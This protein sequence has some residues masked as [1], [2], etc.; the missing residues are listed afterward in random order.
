LEKRVDL[1]LK[2]SEFPLS[3]DDLCQLWLALAH[4]FWRVE[5]VL[6]TDGQGA[7]RKVHLSFQF[8]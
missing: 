5:N 1:H 6:H 3:K 4:R 8:M 2:N 7:I